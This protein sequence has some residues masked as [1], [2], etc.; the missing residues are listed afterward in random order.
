MS[1]AG[2]SPT[3]ASRANSPTG[4]VLT[5]SEQQATG[6]FVSGNP[7]LRQETGETFTIG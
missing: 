7:L 6:G 1:G 4:F 2:I 3:R 5:T